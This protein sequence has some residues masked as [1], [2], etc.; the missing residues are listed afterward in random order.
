MGNVESSTDQ[1][2]LISEPGYGRNANSAIDSAIDSIL[3]RGYTLQ[4]PHQFRCIHLNGKDVV[5]INIKEFGW[6]GLKMRDNNGRYRA[7]FFILNSK[8]WIYGDD[9]KTV[10]FNPDSTTK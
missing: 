5:F 6:C 4:T 8:Q 10:F 9:F 2:Q 1:L 7:Q 3:F